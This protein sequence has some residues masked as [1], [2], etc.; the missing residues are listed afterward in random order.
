MR[1]LLNG[2]SQ[3]RSAASLVLLVTL[4]TATVAQYRNADNC[5]AGSY[6][7]SCSGCKLVG[8]TLKCDSCNNGRRKFGGGSD[9]ENEVTLNVDGCPNGP[10]WNNKG[11][12]MCGDN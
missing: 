4:T 11:R 3:W 2:S 7:K 1:F 12:L 6:L 10:I 8:K 5:P 9:W